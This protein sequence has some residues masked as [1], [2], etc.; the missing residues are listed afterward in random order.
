MLAPSRK[1][2][3]QRAR[4]FSQACRRAIREGRSIDAAVLAQIAA[5][6]AKFHQGRQ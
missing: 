2:A 5:M 1:L 4:A 3:M 6:Y